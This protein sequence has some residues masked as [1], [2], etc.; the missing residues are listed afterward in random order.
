MDMAKFDHR[1]AARFDGSSGSH[2]WVRERNWR[3]RHEANTSSTAV[4][5]ILQ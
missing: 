5:I 4:I 1:F 2:A 3:A